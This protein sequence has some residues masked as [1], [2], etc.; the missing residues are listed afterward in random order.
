AAKCPNITD[1]VVVNA[2]FDPQKATSGIQSMISQ[3]VNAIVIIPDAGVCAELPAMRQATQR[4]IPVAIHAA[5]GCGEVGKDYVSYSD[6]DPVANGRLWAKW[7]A[8]Q[9]GGKGNLLFMGGPAGN[10]VDQGSV[11]GIL[12]ELKNYPD[13]KVLEDLSPKNWPVTNWDP[14]QAQKLMSSLLAK[15]PQI[16]GLIDGY[17]ANVPGEIKAFRDAGRKI[18]PII[19]IQLNALSCE[20]DKAKGT[21]EEF[22]LATISN[23]NWT[24]RLAV[25]HAVA[26]AN[27]IENND[28]GLMALPLLEDSTQPGM[29]PKCYEDEGPDYDPSN[30]MT[31][32]ELQELIEQS[33]QPAS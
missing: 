30:E 27:D 2:G 16:D 18:P 5:D 20:W 12:E 4:G 33:S 21:D 31:D 22:E 13:I 3:G 11:T 8:E 26:A 19:T 14:A 15:Y 29:E 1:T 6:W 9:M 17:G 10:T 23:R 32:E 7:M 28:P 24:G 25:R